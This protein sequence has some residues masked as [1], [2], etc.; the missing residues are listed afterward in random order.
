MF[1]R[2]TINRQSLSG[3]PL[4]LG[5]LAECL[6]FYSKVRVVTD[7]ESFRFLVRCC[8]PD[9]LLE[10]QA[11]GRLEIEFFDNNTAIGTVETNQGPLHQILTF[12]S[13]HTKYQQISRKLFDELSGL[14]GKGANK[15]FMRFDRVVKRSVYTPELEP[16]TQ[17][18]DRDPHG[19]QL[20]SA[21]SLTYFHGPIRGRRC[22]TCSRKLLLRSFPQSA[23]L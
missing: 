18:R 1:E 3:E 7:V 2:I 6:V 9:E 8:G 4:D 15:R 11:I 10:L 13:N 21:R 22:L 17:E 23:R 12:S 5:F 16:R 20:Q 19:P 14:S